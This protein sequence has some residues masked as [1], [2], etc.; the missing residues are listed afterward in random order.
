MSLAKLLHKFSAGAPLLK[1]YKNKRDNL[2]H[3]NTVTNCCI[4]LKNRLAPQTIKG[5]NYTPGRVF[6]LIKTRET[7]LKKELV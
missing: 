2:M 3:L 6:S 1:L 7:F 5:R 4:H